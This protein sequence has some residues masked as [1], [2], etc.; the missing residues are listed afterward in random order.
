MFINTANS[1]TNTVREVKDGYVPMSQNSNDKSAWFVIAD[2]KPI[3]ESEDGDS[4]TREVTLFFGIYYKGDKFALAGIHESL[5]AD[6]FS[7]LYKGSGITAGK[8]FFADSI[9]TAELQNYLSHI[10]SG[11]FPSYNYEG[12][13]GE[14]QCEVKIRYQLV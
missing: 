14:T 5:K 1:Y 4:I 3:E 13:F 9:Q 12:N 6:I 11:I 10:D 7:W 8:T 2:D